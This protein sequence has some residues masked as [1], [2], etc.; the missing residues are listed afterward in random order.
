MAEHEPREVTGFSFESTE[1]EIV[2][3]WFNTRIRTFK[4]EQFNHVE[5]RDDDGALRGLRMGQHVIDML[6]EHEFPYQFDPVIDEATMD[7]FVAAET[8]DLQKELD[9]L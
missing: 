8:K 6:F 2:L 7:W 3:H 5:W 4:D 9:E 1:G